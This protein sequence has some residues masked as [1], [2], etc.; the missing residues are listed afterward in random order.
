ML[1]LQ[2]QALAR[3]AYFQSPRSAQNN[4]NTPEIDKNPVLCQNFE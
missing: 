2:H 4:I 1:K 3:L